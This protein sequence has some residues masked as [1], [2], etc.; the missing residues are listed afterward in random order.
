MFS[1]LVRLLLV[2]ELKTNLLGS[3][4]SE[5]VVLC[6]VFLADSAKVLL[7]FVLIRSRPTSQN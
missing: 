5:F 3:R 6:C 4:D 2:R 1:H 7:I